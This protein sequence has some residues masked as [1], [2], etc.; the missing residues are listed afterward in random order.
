MHKQTQQPAQGQAYDN[1]IN[2][3]RSEESRKTYKNNLNLYMQFVGV[4]NHNLLL[5]I[6]VEESIKRYIIFLKERVSSATLENRVA[7]IYHFYT[8]NDVLLN[9][10]KISQYKGE[11]RKVKKDRAYTH[12]EIG[13]LL[14]ISDLRMKVCILLMAGSGL[15]MGALCELKIK[16]LRDNK[17]T[18]YENSNEEYFT[19]VNPECANFI[20]EYLN[21]RKRV[22]EIISPDSFLIRNHFDDYSNPQKARGITKH[23]IRIIFYHL[24]KKS[25][26]KSNIQLTHGFRKFFTTGL[27][28]SKVNP[29]IRE[30][31]LGHK[32]GLASSYYRP[33]EQEMLEEYQKAEDNLTIDPTNRVER[34]IEM[35]SIEESR[36]DRIEEKMLKMEQMYK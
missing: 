33:T 22:G 24:M 27:I 17:L 34:K 3:I 28:K 15:R 25:A 6:N 5:E 16:H 21:Y 19:F 18:V 31:L 2:T 35:L 20:D 26:I 7:S 36:L 4:T 1:F 9:K 11:Y 29:E 14:Q 13:K 23:N 10:T 8:M 30:M 12:E 32:L